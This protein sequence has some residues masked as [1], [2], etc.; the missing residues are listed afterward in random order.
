MALSDHEQTVLRSIE[1]E[2]GTASAPSTPRR[3]SRRGSAQH[4]AVTTG[5][6]IA[7]L[8]STAVG[9]ALA[10][11]VGTGLGVLGFLLMVA[12]GWSATHLAASLRQRLVARSSQH[13]GGTGQLSQP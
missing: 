4:L 11:K 13:A 7:G 6:L 2:W 1:A 3:P 10:N 8:L 12:S 9:L 5:F